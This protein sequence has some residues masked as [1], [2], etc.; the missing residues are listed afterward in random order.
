MTSEEVQQELLVQLYAQ[1]KELKT[2]KGHLLFQTIIYLLGIFGAM[3]LFDSLSR[4][5]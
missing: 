1:N 5:S 2:M 3:F 4:L